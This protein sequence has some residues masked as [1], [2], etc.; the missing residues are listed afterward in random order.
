MGIFEITGDAT[1]EGVLSKLLELSISMAVLVFLSAVS[2]DFPERFE[3]GSLV[4]SAA[5]SMVLSLG[6]RDDG[7]LPADVSVELGNLGTKQ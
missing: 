4:C 1:G 2:W 3:K 6:W 5:K 7:R